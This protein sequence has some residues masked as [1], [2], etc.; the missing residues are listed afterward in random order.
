MSSTMSS[1][2]SDCSTAQDAQSQ[3]N[4]SCSSSLVY[5][6]RRARSHNPCQDSTVHISIICG[7]GLC[8]LHKPTMKNTTDFPDFVRLGLCCN[9]CWLNSW[10]CSYWSSA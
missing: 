6:H 4:L 10:C 5:V 2:S 7:A 8:D 1:A 9:H 3:G